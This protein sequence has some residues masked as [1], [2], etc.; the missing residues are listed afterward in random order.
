MVTNEKK[1]APDVAQTKWMLEGHR[2][3]VVGAREMAA[4][5]QA[6]LDEFIKVERGLED[7]LIFEKF[8]HLQ[9]VARGE[10]GKAEK[11][12]QRKGHKRKADES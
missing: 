12:K 6:E 8:L 2:E 5:A 1:Q 3:L 7:D 9:K 11:S 10:V 4:M